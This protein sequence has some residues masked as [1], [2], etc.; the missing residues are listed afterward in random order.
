MATTACSA[1]FKLGSNVVAGLR[2]LQCTINGETIDV[3]TFQSSCFNEFI[4]GLKNATITISG[5]YDPTDTNGQVALVAA[6][7]AGTLLTTT[8]KPVYLVDSTKGF[9]FDGYVTSVNAGSTVGSA[10][11]FSATIQSTSTVA[12]V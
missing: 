11:S 2:D 4:A 5:D 12:V 9:T 1:S 8:Q 7:L 10:N 6:N 3:T